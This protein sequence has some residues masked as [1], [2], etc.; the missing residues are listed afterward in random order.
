MKTASPSRPA[1]RGFTMIEIVVVLVV[2]F[3]LM[4]RG[5]EW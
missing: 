3:V 2:L 4:G 5:R 1:V